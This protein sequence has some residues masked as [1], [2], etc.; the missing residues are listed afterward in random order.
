MN[1]IILIFIFVLLLVLT[2]IILMVVYFVYRKLS[3]LNYLKSRPGVKPDK[4]PESEI[5]KD[6]FQERIKRIHEKLNE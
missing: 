1:T 5:K 6:E 3:L 2:I 4:L